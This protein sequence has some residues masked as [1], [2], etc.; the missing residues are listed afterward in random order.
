MPASGNP[1]GPAATYR[2]RRCHHRESQSAHAG[3]R[4][5]PASRACP[6]RSRRV[7]RMAM[8]PTGET[9][10]ITG[11]NVDKV[12]DGRIVEH[13]GAANMLEP[14]LEIGAIQVVGP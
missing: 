3:G 10:E 13:G 2:L 5:N 12:V 1:S 6:E 14:L 11:V 4:A 9:I 8:L 7:C